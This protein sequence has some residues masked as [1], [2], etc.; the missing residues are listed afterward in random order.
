MPTKE[1]KANPLSRRTLELKF[2]SNLGG[3]IVL[4]TACEQDVRNFRFWAGSRFTL[5]RR[6][7]EHRVPKC[8]KRHPCRFGSKGQILVWWVEIN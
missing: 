1:G 2:S 4:P 5:S 8:E 3:R 6:T 7:L